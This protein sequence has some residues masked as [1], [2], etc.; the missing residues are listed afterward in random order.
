MDSKERWLRKQAEKLLPFLKKFHF[1]AEFLTIFRMVFAVVTA[2][3]FLYDRY[4]LTL[5]FFTA[6]Q[7]VLLLDYVDGPLARYQK[8]FSVK[9]A[10]ADR[11]FHYFISLTF[12]LTLSIGYFLNQGNKYILYIGIAGAVFAFISNF[13]SI[14]Q[15]KESQID[16]PRSN[17]RF[18]RIYSYIGIDNPFSVF[19]FLII[20]NLISIAIS[21]Y[22]FL[23]L[24]M[25]LNKIK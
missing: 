3:I 25:L 18:S 17:G 21:A 19:Y 12:I 23:Y 2:L 13:F 14:S 4:L 11:L 7:F 15:F 6:Y 22:S 9:W 5:I 10:K 8:R 16:N 1:A 24:I 20:L